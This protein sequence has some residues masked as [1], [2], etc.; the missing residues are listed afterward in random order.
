[1]NTDKLTYSFLSLRQKLHR[2]AMNFLK[3]EE[4]ANDALQDTFERLWK[5]GKPETDAEARNKLFAV[6]KNVCIDKLRRPHT[7]RADDADTSRFEVQPVLPDD[8]ATL[9]ALLSDGLSEIQK[10]IFLSVSRDGKEYEEIAR[11]TGLT[12]EAVRMTMSRARRKMRENYKKLN[13]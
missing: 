10:S 6:L 5:N 7:E 1:M 4:E 2:S 13:K 12:V 11:E 3:D 8:S 9:E